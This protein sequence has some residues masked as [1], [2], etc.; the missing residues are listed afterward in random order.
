MQRVRRFASI[1]VV[2]SLAV[3]GLSACRS[4]PTV[5]AYVG[6]SGRITETRVQEIW[7]DARA[8]LTEAAAQQPEAA[9]QQPGA[10]AGP[11]AMPITRGDIVRTLVSADVLAQAAQRQNVTVPANLPLGDYAT[12]LRLPQTA[13][14]VRLHAESDA[15]I[16][17]LREKAQNAPAPTDA[18]LRE[19]YDVLIKSKGIEGGTTFEQFKTNLPPENLTLV[20]TAAAVR[21]QV[22]EVASTMRIR[23]NPRYQPLTIPVLEFQAENGE[24]RPLVTVPLGANAD[25]SPVLDVS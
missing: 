16:R 24:L 1:A 8:E 7:D 19:V 22:A 25:D 17:L 3:A 4:E 15:R 12:Q 6:D 11:P 5:A 23:V 21:N 14:Y 20:K 10:S 18:D 2:A 9:A 13:E